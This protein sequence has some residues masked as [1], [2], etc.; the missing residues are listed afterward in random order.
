MNKFLTIFFSPNEVG[1]GAGKA[2]VETTQETGGEETKQPF[3]AFETEDDYNKTIKSERSRAK[4]EVLDELGIKSINEAKTSLSKSATLET[5]L[6]ETKTKYQTLEQ[7]YHLSKVGVKDEYKE[8]VITLAKAKVNDETTFD[9]ALETVV[10]K[11]PFVT[12]KLFQTQVG[13]EQGQ[14]EE[15]GEKTLAD[16]LSKKYPWIKG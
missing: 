10:Q 8:E 5:E 4:K 2:E 15:D 3:K 11:M 1:G 9:K 12:G 13:G 7:D 14:H 16:Q 6:N